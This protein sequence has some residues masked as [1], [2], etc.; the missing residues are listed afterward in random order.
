MNRKQALIKDFIADF[1]GEAQIYVRDLAMVKANRALCEL[2]TKKNNFLA[3]AWYAEGE[4]CTV[5]KAD[6]GCMQLF[7]NEY[8]KAQA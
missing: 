7:R 5:L 8:N 4:L 2:R 3:V 1:A 6:G